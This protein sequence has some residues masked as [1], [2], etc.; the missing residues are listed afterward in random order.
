MKK[1]NI[2]IL[3]YC[4]VTSCLVPFPI[5]STM[6]CS[7]RQIGEGHYYSSGEYIC[8]LLFCYYLPHGL[9]SYTAHR[10]IFWCAQREL[11]S[12]DNLQTKW[13]D[14]KYLIGLENA[15]RPLHP[16][17]N[18]GIIPLVM[19]WLGMNPN[20]A[21]DCAATSGIVEWIPFDWEEFRLH[22]ATLSNIKLGHL[23]ILQ[24]I[25]LCLQFLVS[26]FI[27][28]LC[29]FPSEICNHLYHLCS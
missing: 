4:I 21:Q 11:T 27:Y 6:F 3:N 28:L 29:Y 14:E 2:N 10:T 16:G 7:C 1:N 17:P 26:L 8:Y 24:F 18:F 9:A 22:G 12:I 15:F 19:H 23:V 5:Y 25:S 13:Y 20:C